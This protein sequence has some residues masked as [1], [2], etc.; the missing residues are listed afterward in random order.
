M[1][2]WMDGKDATGYC[3]P[4]GL[5]STHHTWRHHSVQ[6]PA[7]LLALVCWS[8][9]CGK[10][11]ALTSH[12]GYLPFH[13]KQSGCFIVM[14]LLFWHLFQDKPPCTP[15]TPLHIFTYVIFTYVSVYMH[16]YIYG[17]KEIDQHT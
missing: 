6:S 10:G 7:A 8:G 3:L 9:D 12:Q 16:T 14:S 1:D 5:C 17:Y 4:V 15:A 2:G 11:C 13:R